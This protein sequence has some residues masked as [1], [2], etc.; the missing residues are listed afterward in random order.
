L[1][2]RRLNARIPARVDN[3]E[4]EVAVHCSRLGTKGSVDLSA[5]KKTLQG[6]I[7]KLTVKLGPK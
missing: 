5:V 4:I 6:K 3:A 7:D 2:P 1:I